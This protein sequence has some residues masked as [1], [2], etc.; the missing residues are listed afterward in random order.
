MH[1]NPDKN[2]RPT[3]SA[4][5]EVLNK[6]EEVLLHWSEEDRMVHPQA[7]VLGAPLD[8]ASKLYLQLQRQYL[9]NRRVSYLK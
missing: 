1:R 6:P 7:S 3:F 9:Q 4:I 5:V 8:A 2:S